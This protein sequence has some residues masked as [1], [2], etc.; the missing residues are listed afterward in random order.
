VNESGTIVAARVADALQSLDVTWIDHEP[1]ATSEES[2]RV[3][4]T[5]LAS[6]AKAM[7]LECKDE[8]FLCVVPGDRKIDL[9]RARATLNSGRLSLLP[10]EDLWAR[11]QLVPGSVPPF[12]RPILPMGLWCDQALLKHDVVA[13]N[14]GLLCRSVVM[15]TDLWIRV[16]SPR[17][18]T[19]S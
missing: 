16:S 11:Y 15:R 3:R 19:F 14:A 8:C 1:C 17:F 2:A 4:G 10:R 12:G 5:A 13:F 18:C 6:G 7:V 9:K